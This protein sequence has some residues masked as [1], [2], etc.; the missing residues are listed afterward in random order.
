MVSLL[1]T[2]CLKIRVLTTLFI[3]FAC[4]LLP[5]TFLLFNF[6]PSAIKAGTARKKRKY[7]SLNLLDES[8]A[9]TKQSGFFSES[10]L[11]DGEER[12]TLERELR[13]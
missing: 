13:H 12:K 9:D 3:C 2:P 4:N 11:E 10:F 6:S 7:M 5:L 1:F 8:M